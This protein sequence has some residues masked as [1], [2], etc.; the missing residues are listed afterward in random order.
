[1]LLLARGQAVGLNCFRDTPHAFIV[2]LTPGLGI[3]GGSVIQSLAGGAGAAAMNEV[4]ATLCVLLAPA[5]LSYELARF[6]GREA[7]WNRY[8][9]AFNW[10]QWLLP[11]IAFV[12]VAVVAIVRQSGI[13][14]QSVFRALLVC[15]AGYALWL[16]WF[17]ARH[18]LALSVWRAIAMVFCVNLGTITLVFGPTLLASLIG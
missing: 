11:F 9:V 14:G 18:G 3:L 6:W 7:F 4:P 5:V 1:M 12:M 10:C 13:D 8:I 16:N 15:L 2:S 17:I